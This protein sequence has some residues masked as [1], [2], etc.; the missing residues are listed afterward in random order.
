MLYQLSYAREACILAVSRH[1]SAGGYATGTWRPRA[2]LDR[3][4]RRRWG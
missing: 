2:S 3:A 4:S 1:G